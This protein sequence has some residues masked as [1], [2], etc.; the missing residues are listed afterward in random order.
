V[1]I[2]IQIVRA[3]KLFTYVLVLIHRH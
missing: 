3:N 2:P 1:G